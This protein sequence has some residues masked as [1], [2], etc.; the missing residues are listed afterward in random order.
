MSLFH[1]IMDWPVL[2]Y[3]HKTNLLYRALVIVRNQT[4]TKQILYPMI[5]GMEWKF[6]TLKAISFW[7]QQCHLLW[8]N[9]INSLIKW[10]WFPEVVIGMFGFQLHS[11]VIL[12]LTLETHSNGNWCLIEKHYDSS[13]YSWKLFCCK[14][15]KKFTNKSCRW[16]T[17]TAFQTG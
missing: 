11:D 17:M 15:D 2:S 16:T 13:S 14:S 5:C 1:I 7:I 8:Q 4:P 10:V 3:H 9:Y 6:K 12:W